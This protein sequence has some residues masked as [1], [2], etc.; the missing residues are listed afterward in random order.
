MQATDYRTAL[1]H[2]LVRARELGHDGIT[3]ESLT[4]IKEDAD[5]M[6]WTSETLRKSY[7]VVMGG[8]RVML[9]PK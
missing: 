8:L 2:V 5:C 6:G 3:P 1:D 4:A 7:D 9:M